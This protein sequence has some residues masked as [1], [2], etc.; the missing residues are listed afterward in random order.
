MNMRTEKA[1]PANGTRIRKGWVPEWGT[2]MMVTGVSTRFRIGRI[3]SILASFPLLLLRPG[4]PE[5]LDT[6]STGKSSKYRSGLEIPVRDW[7]TRLNDCF[8]LPGGYNFRTIRGKPTIFR[9]ADLP[10]PA[11]RATVKG[12][13]GPAGPLG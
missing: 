11:R 6:S 4:R 3:F 9:R 7:N 2:S 10:P 8:R 13:G 5:S 1:I 12:G